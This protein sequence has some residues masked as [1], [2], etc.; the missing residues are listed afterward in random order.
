MNNNKG[1]TYLGNI[2][3]VTEEY[4]DIVDAVIT[5]G[6]GLSQG[7][8]L[9]FESADYQVSGSVILQRHENLSPDGIPERLRLDNILLRHKNLTY[10]QAAQYKSLMLKA[11]FTYPEA[12]HEVDTRLRKEG[13]ESTLSWLETMASEMEKYAVCEG[14]YTHHSHRQDPIPATYGFHRISSMYGAEYQLPW[15]FRQPEL[16][17]RL[18]TT[19]GRCKSLAQLRNLGKGCYSAQ[20][21]KDPVQYQ[22]VYLAMSNAQRNVFWDRYNIR[23]EKLLSQVSLSDTAR[24]LIK[25]IR[26]YSKDRLP[27]LKTNLVKL[28]KGQ[29]AI[30]NPPKDEEW[31]VVWWH[32]T[33]R[34]SP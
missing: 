21:E 31:D 2:F 17:R 25:R 23:K 18:I 33:K 9:Y 1:L 11:D 5:K 13:A 15:I 10:D 8:R 27:R 12:I 29:I 19:P 3:H 20:N 24:A 30:K 4:E 32:F 28:Q 22:Q 34:K 6:N 14:D 26:T 16:V 7:Q